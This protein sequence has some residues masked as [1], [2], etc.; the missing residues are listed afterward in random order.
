MPT[1]SD[2][3]RD[4]RERCVRAA[5]RRLQTR[6]PCHL[7]PGPHSD[8]CGYFRDRYVYVRIDCRTVRRRPL[9]WRTII[10][11]YTGEVLVSEPCPATPAAARYGREYFEKPGRRKQA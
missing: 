8:G 10:D 3:V 5:R 9:C 6:D 1:M 7:D 11:H 4:V 2:R